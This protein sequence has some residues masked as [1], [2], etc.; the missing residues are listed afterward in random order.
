MSNV[1]LIV[2]KLIKGVSGLAV[3]TE[4]RGGMK[5]LH[6]V[7]MPEGVSCAPYEGEVWRGYFGKTR[8]ST[9]HGEKVLMETF[10]L[11]ERVDE[12]EIIPHWSRSSLA[13]YEGTASYTSGGML[14]REVTVKPTVTFELW[15]SG[16]FGVFVYEHAGLKKIA[17]RLLTN[18]EARTL[19]CQ[20]KLISGPKPKDPRRDAK[21]KD[22]AGKELAKLAKFHSAP[23]GPQE[24]TA[25]KATYI[26]KV[27]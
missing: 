4:N 3:A 16:L 22:A 20:E 15:P 7:Y 13:G 5:I 10:I 2:K 26:Y 25:K 21:M 24:G 9:L 23:R 19:G 14:I 8:T 17:R 1:E 12:M 27:A 18:E 6:P 11:Q